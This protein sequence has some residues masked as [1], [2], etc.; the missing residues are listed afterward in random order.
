[1]ARRRRWV[2]SWPVR[3][4]LLVVVV[5]ANVIGAGVVLVL[6]AWVLPNGPLV[7]PQRVRV[8]NLITFGAYLTVAVLIGAVWGSRR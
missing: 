8:L 3:L 4:A 5:V 2:I 6:S 1:M 7:D